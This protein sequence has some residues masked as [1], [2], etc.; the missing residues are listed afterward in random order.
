[1]NIEYDKRKLLFIF[2]F[3]V[4]IEYFNQTWKVFVHYCVYYTRH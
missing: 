3:S 2:A 4:I 1:M